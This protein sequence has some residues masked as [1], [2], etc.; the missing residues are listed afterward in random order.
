MRKVQDLIAAGAAG[1][2][3]PDLFLVGIDG[4]CATRAEKR[5]E[6]TARTRS[7]FEGRL[8][9][10]CPDPHIEKWYMADP[11]SFHQVVGARPGVGAGK[12]ERG[13][14]RQLLASK[15]R[16]AGH[17]STLGGI[18]W[19]EDLA[20]ELDLYRAGKNDPALGAFLD[21]LKSSLR[22]AP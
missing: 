22:T 20:A 10:A 17:P 6:I 14:Y 12:C 11:D 15:V 19:A 4:N 5:K 13:H 3:M 2:E 18:E 16:E 7:E 1:L 9:I 8:V 21:E